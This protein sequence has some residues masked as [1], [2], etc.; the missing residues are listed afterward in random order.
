M[1]ELVLA[2]V[3]VVVVVAAASS[4]YVVAVADVGAVASFDVVV[5]DNKVHQHQ[6][7]SRRVQRQ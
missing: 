4:S 6:A 5:V 3:V 2:A 1:E 7:T